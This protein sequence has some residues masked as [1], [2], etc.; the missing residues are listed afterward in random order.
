MSWT[1]P[2][3]DVDYNVQ[4][5]D[6]ELCRACEDAAEM[7]EHALS[8]DTDGISDEL[9]RLVARHFTGMKPSPATIAQVDAVVHRVLGNMKRDRII[10][11]FR[12]EQ[13][14]T[15]VVVRMRKPLEIT[16]LTLSL[17]LNEP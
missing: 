13:H 7:V 9:G 4:F 17:E 1:C 15:G 5:S 11:D 6:G 14:P 3:C 12:V 8:A 10:Q 2:G 16:T